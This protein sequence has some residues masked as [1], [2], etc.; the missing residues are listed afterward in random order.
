MKVVFLPGMDGTGELFKPLVHALENSVHSRVI[1][2]SNTDGQNYT[3]LVD[4]VRKR[5]S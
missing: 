2:Y 5:L 1:C 4:E 3:D